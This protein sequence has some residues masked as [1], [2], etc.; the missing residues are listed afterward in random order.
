MRPRRVSVVGASGSGKT[1]LAARLA[2]RLGLPHI[3][4]DDLH[5]LPGWT[6]RPTEEMLALARHRMGG[7][8]WVVDGNY[9]AI[10]LRG[11]IWQE[12]DTVVWLDLPRWR[13]MAQLIPRTLGRVLL[14]RELW[15]GNREPWRNLFVWNDRERNIVVWSW[16]TH[17]PIRDRYLAA[18][19]DPAFAHLRFVRI[20]SRAEASA[21]VDGLGDDSG[22]RGA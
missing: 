1:T 21:F 8:G 17:G 6:Q 22:D 10:T 2:D 3:E 19:T 20:R 12:A 9:S 16:Q 7:P 18:M 5:H 14:R 11:P 15:N 13:I 4:L